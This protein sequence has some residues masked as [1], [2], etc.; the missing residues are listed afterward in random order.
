MQLTTLY[1]GVYSATAAEDMS[2]RPLG[3]LYNAYTAFALGLHA[4]YALYQAP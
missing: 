2:H 1:M 4:V 3:V